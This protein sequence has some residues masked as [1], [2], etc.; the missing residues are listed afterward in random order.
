MILFALACS[1]NTE[2]TSKSTVEVTYYQDVAPI[3]VNNCLSCHRENGSG[4][5]TLETYEMVKALGPSIVDSI[6]QRRMPPFHADNSGDC[7]NFEHSVWMTDAEI[8]TI[9]N[10]VDGG[11]IEGDE[12]SIEIPSFEEPD[13]EMTHTVTF[14]PYEASF[15][16]AADDY[17]CFIVDPGVV[18]EGFLTGFEVLPSNREI[19]HHMILYAPTSTSALNQAIAK[20]NAD[21]GPG[22]SCYGDP[23]VAN[24]MIAP[25][26][27]GTDQWYYPS[28]TGIRMEE[29]QIL[30]LQMHY[31]NASEDTLDSTTVNLN[32]QDTVEKEL[33]TEFFVHSDLAIPANESSHDES[34]T[35]KIKSFSGYDGPL[36]LHAIGPHMHTLGVSSSAKLIREDGSESCVIDVPYYDFN[37]QRVYTYSEPILLQPDDRLKIKCEFDSSNKDSPTYWGD[38]TGDE[39]CLMTIF[40]TLPE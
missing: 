22:Y 9:G 29:G 10:W 8:N 11:M 14:E 3:I 19:A 31:S 33:F 32:I 5:F 40:A 26:A 38:G 12:V 6:S 16:T 34:T 17:R 37:W 18:S 27:P 36:M 23:G 7:Q 30:I 2:D 28:G 13:F 24:R 1:G 21:D 4:P 20:D 15:A 39:M 25:W 35:Q